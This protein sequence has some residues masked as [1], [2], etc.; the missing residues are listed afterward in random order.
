MAEILFAA[1][2]LPSGY[3]KGDPIAAQ[4]DGWVWG[5]AETLPNFWQIAVSGLPVALVHAYVNTGLWE[6]AIIGDPEYDAPDEADRRIWRHR[7]PIRLMWD[8]IAS[9]E[10]G[11]ITTLEAVGRLEITAA[12]GRPYVR[13]LRYNRGQGQVEKSPN[14]V[15]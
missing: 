14:E 3:L 2:D 15:F 7:R 6:L 12:Q 13:H 10:P 5:S 11:W 9:D 8:E 1:Q 4:D